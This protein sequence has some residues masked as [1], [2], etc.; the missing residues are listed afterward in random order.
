MPGGF[1]RTPSVTGYFMNIYETELNDDLLTKMIQL[2]EDWKAENSCT[3]YRVNEKA[4]IEGNRIFLAEDN[5]KIIGYLFGKTCRAQD[6]S[7]VMA[8]GTLY[9][10]V[11]ELYVIPER[12]SQGIGQAL[13]N[14]AEE[15]VKPEAEYIVL[16]TATKNWKAI[17]HFYLEEL[18]MNFWNARMYK[19]IQ[20]EL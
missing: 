12:R 19:K 3:G 9:F 11:E 7:S 20:E 4:D 5:D 16:S 8:E 17:L 6:M 10:E 1:D 14:Y 13:F 15:T 2:S 18:N